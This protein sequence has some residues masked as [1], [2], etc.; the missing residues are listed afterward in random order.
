[1][2]DGARRIADAL[3]S[4]DRVLVTGHVHPDGDALGSMAAAA[5]I[6]QTLGKRWALFADVPVP[7]HLES[8]PLPGPVLT[9]PASL[10][11]K[12]ESALLLDFN[13]TSR[14][15]PKLA[16]LPDIP[17][18]NVD[19]HL[20]PNGG[21]GTIANWLVPEAAATA[22]LVAYVALTLDLPLQGDM[23]E[24]LLHGI[25][26]DTGGFLHGNTGADVLRLAA[27]IVEQ[28]CD[29]SALRNRM[30]NTWTL[31]QMRLWSR[32]MGNVTLLR[33][34]GIAFCSVSRQDMEETGTGPDGTEG[35]VEQ[36]RQL[37]GVA[38]TALLREDKDRCKFSLRSQGETD[39]QA[40][41][42][43][44]GGG[45]HR[46]AA[47]GELFTSLEEA[48]DT[49]IKALEAMPLLQA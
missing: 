40:V 2:R 24:A 21:L 3:K 8:L 36:M 45:G 13:D 28:G 47:G 46:N 6:L 18:V 38:V 16:P 48:K 10:P 37:R 11:F 23:A 43:R 41:A 5:H 7:P 12:P 29:M 27:H 22:Q 33:H 17:V 14:L 1:M 42:A 44:F 25:V 35:F 26:S 32:L 20:A 49:L 31:G 34:D 39:V 15:A 9:E 4:V 19:H 30:R